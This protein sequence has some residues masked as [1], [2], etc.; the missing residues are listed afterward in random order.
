MMWGDML[1][2]A[3]NGGPPFNVSEAVSQIPKDVVIC[4]WSTSVDPL[5]LAFF[6]ANGFSRIIKSNSLGCS[7][8]DAPLVWGNMWGVWSKLPWL[9]ETAE[10]YNRYNFLHIMQAA[11]YSW[12]LHPD[13]YH[14]VG[15]ESAF[16]ESRRLALARH[17]LRRCRDAGEML[18]WARACVG[19]RP[20][21]TKD[22]AVGTEGRAIGKDALGAGEGKW[23]VLVTAL[24]CTSDDL[25]GLR[26]RLKDK[27]T[28]LGAPVADV[29]FRYDDGQTEQ[30]T[31]NFGYHLRA[32]D[33][34]GLPYVY[35]GVALTDTSGW[36]AVPV[37]NPNP[38]KTV[39]SVVLKPRANVGTLHLAG[40]K[41]FAE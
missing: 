30:A 19:G 31:L 6:R 25:A 9:V 1:L 39:E 16:F 40:A 12:N 8:A 34:D 32:A 7:A 20:S 13:M 33:C 2:P 4:D 29:V 15:F 35:A 17:A 5:S 22:T 11:Q 18:G 21:I 3:H 24:K 41:L 36:Y 27:S 14:N 26:E 23:L 10:G 37:E 38:G 28:W